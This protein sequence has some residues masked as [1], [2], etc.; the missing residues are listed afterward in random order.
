MSF[1][2][3]IPQQHKRKVNISKQEND[4]FRKEE[5][6][7]MTQSISSFPRDEERAS[8]FTS[9]RGSVSVEAALVTPIF[10]LAICCL[11]YL[12]EIMAIQSYV[13]AAL[14]EEG[15]RIAKEAYAKPFVSQK[16]VE[17][18]LIEYIGAERLN[19]SMI[20]GG[21]TGLDASGTMIMPGTGM[22]TMHVKYRIL[23]PI[24]MFGNLTMECEDGFRVKG[25]NGYAE[26][27]IF[28]PREDIVYITET[29]VVY[30]KDYHCTHLEL[31]VRMVSKESIA[32]LRND[33][34]GKY[35]ACEMCGIASGNQVYIT[36]QGNRYHSSPGC[37]GLKRR[38]YAVPISEVL[39]KGACTRCGS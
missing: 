18:D 21:S 2:C 14:H 13:R 33:N 15:R 11:C 36:R 32:S 39:G 10:F 38:V 4:F 19:R 17:A 24:S 34:G 16:Q 30:H 12:L 5:D 6:S 27:G 28:T 20:K 37:S 9:F 8:L 35:H 31:S 29:G 22:V 3:F 23:L 7:A 1:L 26:N 25:W